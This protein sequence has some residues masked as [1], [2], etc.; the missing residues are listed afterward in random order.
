MTLLAKRKPLLIG[1]AILI[2]AIVVG[3]RYLFGKTADKSAAAKPNPL[4]SVTFTKTTDLPIEFSAQGHLVALNQVEVRPQITGVI[5]TVAFHEGDQIKAGQLLFTLDASDATA[6]MS[7]YNAQ[8]AQI[9]AQLDDANRD[10][11]RSKELVKSG[12]ISSSAVTTSQSKVETL[13][14]QLKAAAAEIES[15]RV[16]VDHTRITAPI[17]GQAGALAIHP[18]SLAQ[19]SAAS[20]LVTLMQMD[21]IG[22]EFSLP[23]QA[24]GPI[25]AARAAGQIKATLQTQDNQTA[26]GQLTFVNN[27]VNT[28]TAT[29][30]LKASFPNAAQRL[31]PGGFA[32]ITL[33]AG[34]SKGA[35]VLPPHA[36]LEG[37]SGR[38][39]YVV[40][41]DNKATSK[42]VTLLRIQDGS[43]VLEGLKSGERV[44]LDGGQ[45][46]SN[47]STVTIDNKGSPAQPTDKAGTKPA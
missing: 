23:E 46:L 47:G 31:W 22:M 43:A 40:G 14:A 19:T 39:V 35:V 3:Q 25:L 4:V 16:Q 37:P 11:N 17:S 13:Q 41:S 5:R 44:V 28:D 8:S 20:P 2:L 9:K 1:V 45:N 21:P 18:G 26:E 38:F 15:A 36:I 24:L 33:R 29:I 12:F 30:N 7:R 10:Y 32:H 27:T 6:Q 34:T 42:P